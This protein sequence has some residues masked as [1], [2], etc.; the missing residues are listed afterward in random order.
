MKESIQESGREVSIVIYDAPLPPKYFRFTKKFIRTLF[1][2]APLVFILLSGSLILWGLGTKVSQ[3]PRPSLPKAMTED[4]G[5]IIALENELRELKASHSILSEKLAIQPQAA[6]PDDSF[7]M[8][9]K[10]P[11]GMQNLTHL[12]KV[13]LDQFELKQDQNKVSLKFQ[14][15]HSNPEKRVTGHVIV[16]MISESGTLVYPREANNSFTAGIKYSQGEPFAVSRLRPTNA[17]FLHRL[18]GDSVRFVVYIF[19][20]EGDLLLLQETPSYKVEARP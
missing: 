13:S 20:R 12:N 5:K 17:E 1:V 10:K 14:I 3:A 6:S 8:L 9:I 19:S 16:F 7:L 18:A 11:Y 15:I 4:G 2:V